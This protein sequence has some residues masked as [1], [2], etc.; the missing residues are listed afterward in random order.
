MVKFF[1]MLN[2]YNFTKQYLNT[3]TCPA[4]AGIQRYQFNE[5]DQT[6]FIAISVAANVPCTE[7]KR[8]LRSNAKNRF[9]DN[10]IEKNTGNLKPNNG[11]QQK[12]RG[13]RI[14]ENQLQQLKKMKIYSTT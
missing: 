2:N 7:I 8:K 13:V 1:D 10:T 12:T 14:Q 3:D 11:C 4:V 5:R 9:A 6:S